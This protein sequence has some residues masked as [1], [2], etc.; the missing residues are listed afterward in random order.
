MATSTD[1]TGSATAGAPGRTTHDALVHGLLVRS[2]HPLPAPQAPERPPGGPEPEPDL[3][4]TW[5][6]PREV[7]DDAPVGRLVAELES[8]W[9][10]S[11]VVAH[12]AG[13]TLWFRGVGQVELDPALRTAV[14]VRVPGPRG[15][16]VD[17]L[18]AGFVLATVL[19]LRGHL[20]LHASA[21]E[22]EGRA[23]A[24]VGASGR[25]KSTLATLLCSDGALLVA[26]DVLRVDLD[27]GPAVRLGATATRL[28]PKAASLAAAHGASE[29]ADHRLA[30]ELAPSTLDPCPLAVVLLPRPRRDV[31]EVL[32]VR[33]RGAAALTSLL[34]APRILGWRDAG[35]L[36]TQMRQLS[37]LV[38]AVPVLEAHVP[39]GPPFP[40]G[41]GARVLAA[42]DHEL[43]A[44]SD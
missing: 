18:V 20:V 24:V 34:A 11:A 29:T 4:I 26:D 8:G 10:R 28:R 21:V 41:L 19:Q 23:L 39:W 37:R 6:T 36:A 30:V 25:G 22:H 40:S 13:W 43:R 14:V 12:E 1:A 31:H 33:Q 16:V 2:D 44:P 32:V 3:T 15:D 5:A 35:G 7:P 9:W 38:A 42:V 27:D 17:V